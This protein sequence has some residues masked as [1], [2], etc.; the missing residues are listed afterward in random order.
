MALF[1]IAIKQSWDT[2]GITRRK[3]SNV[4][5]ADAPNADAAAALGVNL[6]T[7]Y[8]RGAARTTVFAYEVY[9]TSLLQGDD[10]YK[11]QSVP[12]AQSRGTLAIPSGEAYAPKNCLSITIPASQGRPS[13]KYW[14]PG[15]WESDVVA[16][17][18]VN[19][20][21]VQAVESAFNS[22]LVTE[23][24]VDPDGQPLTGQVVARF[25]SRA[26]G[27]ESAENVPLPPPQG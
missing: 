2:A 19:S 17:Q 13:R 11:I 27:R 8:L 1:S 15:L 12:A 4:F 14:R 26:F 22:M 20:T 5:F 21:L 24:L 3:W 16:G 6:W 18:A 23:L 7:T 9:A 10:V 25:T